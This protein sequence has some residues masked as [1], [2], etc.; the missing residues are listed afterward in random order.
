V[1]KL[2]ATIWSSL[3]LYQLLTSNQLLI[4]SNPNKHQYKSN[5]CLIGGS[6]CKERYLA[7]TLSYNWN[8]GLIQRKK[9]GFLD[10][11]FFL[12]QR[13]RGKNGIKNYRDDHHEFRD[14]WWKFHDFWISGAIKINSGKIK[15]IKKKD[16]ELRFNQG[17]IW[18]QLGDRD[19]SGC[20]LGIP[21]IHT[22]NQRRERVW[23]VSAPHWATSACQ[24]HVSA[25][26]WSTSSRWVPPLYWPD[27]WVPPTCHV[28]G[29]D[30]STSLPSCATWQHSNNTPQQIISHLL[31]HGYIL[32]VQLGS[33]GPTGDTWHSLTEATSAWINTMADD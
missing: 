33:I 1:P 21:N 22:Q 9:Q 7:E 16:Q 23:H 10:K 4:K 13:G 15:Q 5:W 30:R 27:M 29:S 14:F 28:A 2:G 18:V 12:I 8:L 24:C 26:H 19:S 6:F 31:P 25:P 11:R 32:L 20:K 17:F 3:N